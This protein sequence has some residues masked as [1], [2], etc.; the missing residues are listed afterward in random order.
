MA[1]DR[2]V[3][4]IYLGDHLA[5]MRAGAALVGRMRGGGHHGAAAALLERAAA[6]LDAGQE[7]ATVLLRQLGAGPPL[8]KLAAATLGER[9]GRMK[10][11]GRI[12]SRS[13]LSDVLELEGL[14]LVL[15]GSAALWRA[16][17]R[18]EVASDGL[19]RDHAERCEALAAEVE[20]ARL[21]RATDVLG[22]T[23]GSVPR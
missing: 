20:E 11:N 13:P 9:L 21:A 1:D 12:A 8:A 19:V 15:L 2:R 4:R 17:E 18:A 23:A 16:L 3:L 5:M 6:E 22:T 10:L 7:A 14:G